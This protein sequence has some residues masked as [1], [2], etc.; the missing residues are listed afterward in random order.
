M[1]KKSLLQ[2]AKAI[3][4]QRQSGFAYTKEMEEV[5]LA[6]CRDEITHTQVARALG[7]DNTGYRTYAKLALTLKH[8]L[9][10]SVLSKITK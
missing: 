7:L 2:K 3:T 9:K 6:W 10:K 1:N 4:P 5:A 8:Y